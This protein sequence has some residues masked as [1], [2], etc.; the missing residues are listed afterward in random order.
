MDRREFF[1]VMSAAAAAQ[2]AGAQEPALPLPDD[3]YPE[4]V[5]SLDQGIERSIARQ[6]PNGGWLDPHQIP[7]VIS[8]AGA[9]SAM[10]AA[11]LAP[12]S[13]HFHQAALLE[14]MERAADYLL[15]VQN[16]DGTVTS[17]TTNFFSPPDTAF[18]VQALGPAAQVL[19]S[20]NDDAT[21]SVNE[22]LE[23]F[24]HRGGE[25]LISGGIHTPNHR[26]VVSAALARC[27]QLNPDPRYLA[28]IEQWLAEGFD[29]DSEGQ[30]NERST[31]TYDEVSDQAFILLARLLD[32]PA[33]YD[34]PRKNMET[35]LYFLRPND[36]IATDIS[37]RQDRFTA[38]SVLHYYRCYRFMAWHDQNG[39]FASVAKYIERNHLPE[40]GGHVIDFMEIPELRNPLPPSEPIPAD[41]VKYYP[42]SSFVH[43][44]RGERSA[45]ILGDD[46]R[47]FS[48]RDGGAVVEA[49]RVAC[50]Y[51]GRGQFSG[52]LH[53]IEGGFRLEQSLDGF[54]YQ[55]LRPEDRGA[56]EDWPQTPRSLRTRSNFSHL[57][58]SVEIREVEA[59]CALTLNISGVDQVPVAVEVTLRPGGKLMGDLQTPEAASPNVYL[60]GDGFATYELAG[61]RVQFGP[62][63]RGHS[64]TQLRG[65]QPRLEGV[66]VYMTGF[67]PLK[68]AIQFLAVT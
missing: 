20:R 49:V 56:H 47:F 24:L 9:L 6:Q 40:M 62:G 59:G 60:L 42:R 33:L 39:R 26:W 8:S 13:N 29:L 14:R 64:W 38:V 45:T 66:S 52:P 46:F 19:R 17:Y 15:R 34:L 35:L 28:R 4:L 36:E 50:A 22:K 25:A 27:H 67:T 48:F 58:S 43:I 18:V 31:G 57:N 21:R 68:Q 65:A 12:E 5:K 7:S 10:T 30:F 23:A 32:R 55:P 16:P 1:G 37:H 44:R 2:N 41:Y 63:F 53:P 61:S 3:I 11:F 54:Y 51:F